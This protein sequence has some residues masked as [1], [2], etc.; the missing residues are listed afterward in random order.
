MRHLASV[1]SSIA[2][3]AMLA[4]LAPPVIGASPIA[5]DCTNDPAALRTAV[6]T[7]PSDSML[8]ISGTC[9]GVLEIDRDL[10]ITPGTS[11]ARLTSE[12]FGVSPSVMHVQAG[13]R[14]L[15]KGLT[16]SG[17]VIPTDSV[18]LLNDGTLIL[19]DSTVTD[20]SIGAIR[21]SGRLTLRR[22]AVTDNH[23]KGDAPI[24]NDGGSVTL[25]RS[26][27]SGNRNT[28]SVGAIVNWSG[29]VRLVDSTIRDNQGYTAV[30]RNLGTMR[31]RSSTIKG[32]ESED[33]TVDNAGTMSF[34]DSA[35]RRN[36][37]NWSGG[38]IRNSG[39]LRLRH[40]V[41]RRNTAGGDGGGIWNEGAAD[42]RHT[43]VVGNT[44]LG[45]GGGIFNLGSLTLRDVTIR[46]NTPNNCVGC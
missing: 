18:Q 8:V 7:V 19:E 46:R 10:V 12:N 45:D 14:V 21:N 15:L 31:F 40:A 11:D 44:A 3:L 5:V 37:S 23:G 2:M 30:V 38:G 4:M 9:V 22:S 33:T 42:L 27:V 35:V 1:S 6:A 25:I 32:N 13:V 39:N 29:I 28:E 36:S 20:G 41:V 16:I 43:R 24:M 26:R 17:A 34:R